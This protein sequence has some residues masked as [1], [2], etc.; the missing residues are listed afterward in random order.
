MKST[1][2]WLVCFMA[3]VLVLGMSSCIDDDDDDEKTNVPWTW[4]EIGRYIDSQL[5][6]ISDGS[7]QTCGGQGAFIGWGSHCKNR[8]DGTVDVSM[9][10]D[11][12][13]ITNDTVLFGNAAPLTLFNDGA[14][15]Q[16]GNLFTGGFCANSCIP[17]ATQLSTMTCTDIG[18]STFR[19]DFHT[20]LW[21]GPA[22]LWQLNG[23]V[24]VNAYVTDLGEQVSTSR[25]YNGF[26]GFDLN[27]G[28]SYTVTGT[29]VL[30]QQ[31]NPFTGIPQR[32]STPGTAATDGMVI[33]DITAS[34]AQNGIASSPY[35]IHV[36]DDFEDGLVFLSYT[37]NA[38]WLNQVTPTA[39]DFY[40]ANIPW[41]NLGPGCLVNVAPTGGR[42]FNITSP[43]GCMPNFAGV[44]Y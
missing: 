36:A 29:V 15:F 28:N 4:E 24:E 38:V 42:T 19:L 1:G 9:V 21:Q 27:N 37:D 32:G 3:M 26:T 23:T 20:C 11:Y 16:H 12:M 18:A 22:A 17:S 43:N 44:I 34:V 10:T 33:L 13:R 41:N 35:S 5:G 31:I 8:L 30:Y 7:A 39:L 2:R 6:E 14:F 40:A 25:Y